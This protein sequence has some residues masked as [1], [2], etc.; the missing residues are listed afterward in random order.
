VPHQVDGDTI[1]FRLTRPAKVSEPVNL[2]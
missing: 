1:S 2:S